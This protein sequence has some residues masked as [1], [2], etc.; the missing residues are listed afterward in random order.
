MKKVL[1]DKDGKFL[2]VHDGDCLTHEDGTIMIYRE[3]KCKKDI[4]KAIPHPGLGEGGKY[5][6]K[7]NEHPLPDSEILWK[8]YHEFGISPMY[9]L[10]DKEGIIHEADAL[11]E[12]SEKECTE[13]ILEIVSSLAEGNKE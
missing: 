4:S 11:L 13:K 8:I 3:R 1:Y 9:I 5:H 6:I 7:E 12:I 2:S 10:K